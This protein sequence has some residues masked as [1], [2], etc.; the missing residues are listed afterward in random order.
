MPATRIKLNPDYG[1]AAHGACFDPIT[2]TIAAIG[3]A[4]S[5]AAGT[6]GTVGTI[7]GIAGSGISALGAFQQGQNAKA[8]STTRAA[9]MEQQANQ[10]RASSQRTMLE[11]QRQTGMVQSQ[12]QSRAAASGA[13]ATDD[14]VVKLG[15]DIA[16][17]GE[18]QALM[19]LYNGENTAR[20]LEDQA[21]ATRL[22]GRAAARGGIMSAAGTLAS[23]F[24]N[25]FSRFAY[26][27]TRL[28][29]A[30]AVT[31]G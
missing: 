6:L 17:R 3:S 24:G 11:H 15:S 18:E 31:A 29:D 14:T 28:P 27:P 16:G 5:A 13:G 26:S 25:S 10:A 7:M 4:A 1:L 22:Q 9:Q 12:L 21:Q 20:G 23:G 19:D 8:A 2:M 30:Q